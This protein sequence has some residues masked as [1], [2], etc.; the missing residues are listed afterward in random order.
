MEEIRR[1][2]EGK[3]GKEGRKEQEE[4]RSFCRLDQ[5]DVSVAHLVETSLLVLFRFWQV[6]AI[7]FP[8]VV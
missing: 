1:K 7:G 6:F 3:E 8:N 2:S 5:V 4:E